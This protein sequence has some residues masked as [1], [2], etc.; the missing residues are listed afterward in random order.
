MKHHPLSFS[1]KRSAAVAARSFWLALYGTVLLAVGCGDGIKFAPVSGQV[2][3]N[4]KPLANAYVNFQPIGSAEN[5][6]PGRGSYAITD[7]DGKYTLRS[8]G[9]RE[10]AVVGRHRVSISTYFAED[11]AVV[12]PQK[13][14]RDDA[15]PPKLGK[16]GDPIPMRYNG[17]TKLEFEVKPGSNVANWPLNTP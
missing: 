7:K 8:D 13:G 5:P 1:R 16:G 14:S 9:G 12:D 6:N 3:M 2:T 15:P 10:G 4:D 17:D 11:G